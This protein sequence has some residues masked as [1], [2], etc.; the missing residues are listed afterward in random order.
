MF[1]SRSDS[2]PRR[3]GFTLIELLVVIAIIALL[4]SLLLPGLWRA[5]NLAK[6]LV[7]MSNNRQLMS[8]MSAYRNDFKDEIPMKMSGNTTAWCTWSFGG[9]NSNARWLGYA[10]GIFDEPAA[11]R[12]LNRYVYADVRWATTPTMRDREFQQAPL[13]R[14]PGDKAS[15]QYLDPYPTPDYTLSSY[16]DVGTSYHINMK[17][18]D[19]LIRQYTR[20]P[21]E[22]GAAFFRRVL[23][24]GT[25]RIRFASDTDPTK[26]IWIH[27]QT[28]DIVAH[29]SQRRNWRGEFND[30][31][32]SVVSFLD[33]HTDYIRIVPGAEKG[34][35][36]TF[37][38]N[39]PGDRP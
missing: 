16:D 35:G 25:R 9:K 29:D 33:G 30:V 28:A 10:G 1:D 39:L 4:V 22:T 2:S 27:D 11:G 6:Q 38:F 24:E 32:M 34:P 31:N 36:Y 17:W 13:F 23:K 37:L 15:F 19:R 5:R 21:A 8:G 3:R 12:P 14:S 26:F 18:W 7:S 20:R